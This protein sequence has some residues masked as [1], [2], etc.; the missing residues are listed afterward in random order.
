MT[1][2]RGVWPRRLI[3]G[4]GLG[5]ALLL[6]GACEPRG[7]TDVGTA[8][9]LRITAV[10]V[11]VPISTLVVDVTAADIATPLVFN[12][13]VVNGVAAGTIKL[14]PGP[15]RTI[16]V[17][18]VD[19]AGNVTHE[20][21]TTVDVQPGQ[22]APLQIRLAPRSGHVPITVTFGNY[23][24][25]LTPP[26]ATIDAAVATTLQLAVTVTDVDGNAIPSAEVGWATTNPAVA[27]VDA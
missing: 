27:T 17:M 13:E 25:V 20:G 12:L 18:A 19:D 3:W 16:H 4:V 15:A 1:H 7:P 23:G 21:S 5:A 9:P 14:P 10:V 8:V 11:G 6:A 2:D 26:A 24:V 22:N